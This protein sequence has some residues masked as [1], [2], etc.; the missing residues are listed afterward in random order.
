MLAA[1]KIEANNT[2]ENK[3]NEKK[4]A[5]KSLIFSHSEIVWRV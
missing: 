4:H 1:N 3:H 2:T 5:F